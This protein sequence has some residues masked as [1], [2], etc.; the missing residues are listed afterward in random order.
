MLF[1][2]L[3]FLIALLSL[4]TLVGNWIFPGQVRVIKKNRLY[5]AQKRIRLFGIPL[6]LKASSIAAETPRLI[7]PDYVTSDGTEYFQSKSYAIDFSKKL[8]RFKDKSNPIEIIWSSK[9]EKS[10][11]RLEEE[12]E[13]VELG[14]RL[15]K[16][17]V[18]IT[19]D[20]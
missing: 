7:F 9:K 18:P 14:H 3:K 8:A 15:I 12:E 4:D 16:Q 11:R 20:K 5:Y 19:L 2:A 10:N 1:L 17:N 6:W 13:L